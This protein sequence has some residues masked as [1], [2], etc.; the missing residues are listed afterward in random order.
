MAFLTP[1]VR[2]VRR[3]P[4]LLTDDRAGGR[5]GTSVLVAGLWM[6]GARPRAMSS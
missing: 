4:P 5:A 1:R 3:V 6:L 2:T